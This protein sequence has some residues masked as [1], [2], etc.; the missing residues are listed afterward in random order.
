MHAFPS[1]DRS[2]TRRLFSALPQPDPGP[3]AILGDE[4]DAGTDQRLLKSAQGGGVGRSLPGFEIRDRST[5]DL[6]PVG[7]ILLRPTYKAASS[8]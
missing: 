7:K 4:L 6:S 3:A 2:L 1:E 8:P 5:S